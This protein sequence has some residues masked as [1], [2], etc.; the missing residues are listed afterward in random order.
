MRLW[1]LRTMLYRYSFVYLVY[2]DPFHN[3]VLCTP[4]IMYSSIHISYKNIHSIRNISWISP[5]II[6]INFHD[7]IEI[8]II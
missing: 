8:H 2:P 7:F 1:N 6:K 3:H 5:L 4:G